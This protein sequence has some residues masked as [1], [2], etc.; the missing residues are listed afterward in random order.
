MNITQDLPL[1]LHISDIPLSH[2][3]LVVALVV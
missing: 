3:S 1:L 2:T